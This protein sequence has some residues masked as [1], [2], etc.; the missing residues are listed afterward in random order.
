MPLTRR[1]FLSL[2]T[3]TALSF[4]LIG[5][6][7]FGAN[8]TIRV[9]LI[10]CGNRGSALFGMFQGIP[11]VEMVAICDPDLDCMAKLLKNIEK[12]QISSIP[13]AD[14][15]NEEGWNLAVQSERR[16]AVEFAAAV[17]G[18]VK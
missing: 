9:A 5:S 15:E 1:R 14:P 6:R 12:K 10:G 13:K 3:A 2:T 7:V 11:G 17:L 4:P 8:N 18:A 16:L